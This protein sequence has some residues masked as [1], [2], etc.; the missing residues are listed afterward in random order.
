MQA[1]KKVNVN[2]YMIP[3][4]ILYLSHCPNSLQGFRI[5]CTP[6]H[7]QCSPS[8]TSQGFLEL[9]FPCSLL[10]RITPHILRKACLPGAQVKQQNKSELIIGLA[11][12]FK[13]LYTVDLHWHILFLLQ[14]EKLQSKIKRASRKRAQL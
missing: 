14:G 11:P 3:T 1:W 5:Q 13:K 2:D 9:E 7:S 10:R 6:L 12:F 8:C 4:V